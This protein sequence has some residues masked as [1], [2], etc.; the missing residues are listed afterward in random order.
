MAAGSGL[1]SVR[2]QNDEATRCAGTHGGQWLWAAVSD[3]RG[4]AATGEAPSDSVRLA[5][6]GGVATERGRMS[7]SGLRESR[8]TRALPPKAGRTAEGRRVRPFLPGE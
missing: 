3:L 4:A 8:T 2:C 7:G 1:A 5:A 6:C